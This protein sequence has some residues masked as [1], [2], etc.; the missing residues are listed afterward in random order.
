MYDAI[1]RDYVARGAR[2]L[3]HAKEAF[4]EEELADAVRFA[5]ESTE[6]SLKAALRWVG[7]DYP[8]SHDVGEVMVGHADRFPPWFRGPLR[9][10]APLS[11]ELALRR[12][13]A[14][15]GLEIEG[16]PASEIFA[17]KAE[18]KSFL[19]LAARVQGMVQ[20][21]LGRKRRSGR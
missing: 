21:L 20:R 3:R 13:L 10:I 15:Y 4:S 12:G 8:R 14:L 18:V 7:I 19:E 2:Y 5:Q 1:A 11:H 16:T 9:E 17:D 6:L